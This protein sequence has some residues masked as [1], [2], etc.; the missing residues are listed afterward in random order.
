MFFTGLPVIRIG[1]VT[2]DR[3]LEIEAGMKSLKSQ[4]TSRGRLA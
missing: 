4:K 2:R 3:L 1:R